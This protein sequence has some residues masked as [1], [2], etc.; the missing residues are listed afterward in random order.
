MNEIFIQRL[1]R[2]GLLSQNENVIDSVCQTVGIQAQAKPNVK[3]SLIC[4]S[5]PKI[6][7]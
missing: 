2:H 6:C 7:I 1:A 4:H 5:A 3:L